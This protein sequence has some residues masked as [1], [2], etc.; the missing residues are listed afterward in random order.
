MG[1]IYPQ[2]IQA[3]GKACQIDPVPTI[4]QMRS[5]YH[6]TINVHDFKPMPCWLGPGRFRVCNFQWPDWDKWKNRLLRKTAK[7]S[8][9]LPAPDDQNGGKNSRLSLEGVC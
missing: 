1:A 6:L 4:L 9:Q 8:P 5:F 7:H 3:G 2:D